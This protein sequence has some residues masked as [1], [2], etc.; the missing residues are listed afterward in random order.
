MADPFDTPALVASLTLEETGPDRFVGRSVDLGWGSIFG[1]QVLAQALDAAER[2]VPADRPVHAMHAWFLRRGDARAPVTLEVER[3]RDGGSFTTR[4]VRASQGAPIFEASCSF[5]TVE[6]GLDHQAAAPDVPGPDDLP[7]PRPYPPGLPAAL[8]QRLSARTPIEMRVVDPVDLF[9]PE[10]RP[11]AR[12]VWIRTTE[13]I[14]DDPALHRRLL[15]YTSDFHFLTTSLQ[16]HA[17]TWLTPGLHLA[18]L[19]HSIWFH[20]S[21]RLDD[22]LLYDVDGP[23]AA[24]GRAL[25]QGRVYDRAGR[26]VALTAQEGL[27][28]Q[29]LGS[30]R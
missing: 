26:L 24:G 11:A 22:W 16:P 29:T 13:P 20:R 3:V 5:Q 7:P 18:S 8:V 15:A 25:V 28:R 12:R 27:I 30:N 9:R 23:S 17:V 2:T 14:A 19:D 6:P 10:R 4:R 1:G 21:F